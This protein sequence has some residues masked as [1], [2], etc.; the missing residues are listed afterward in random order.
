[1]ASGDTDVGICADALRMLGANVI[2]SFTDGTEASGLC[3]ALYPDIRDSTLTMYKWSWGTKKVVLAQSTTTPINE[4]KYAYPL[5]AD[6]IA[7]N[8]IAVFNT[9]NTFTHPI[10]SFEIYGNELFTNETTIYIDYV[11][12]VPEDLM[13]TYFVQLLKYMMAW[14]LA[15][16]ITDQTEKGNYWRNIALGGPSENNR[17]G[18]FRQAMNIDGRGNPPQAIV[19]FPLVE[20]RK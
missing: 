11:Y 16:P 2:T 3:Q 19:D 20:I 9:S 17:G 12:R 6:A 4:W 8:P 7:G 14:H 13:P 10:Q 15:E 18:Y 1:M 5:P